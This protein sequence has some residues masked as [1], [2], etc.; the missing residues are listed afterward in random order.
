[1][2]FRKDALLY[3]C[4]QTFYIALILLSS[5]LI[6]IV[7]F[8]LAFLCGFPFLLLLPIN[9]ALYNEFITLD[10]SGISCQKT[11]K[12]VWRYRWDEIAELKRGSRFLLPSIEIIA[13]SRNGTPEQF[14]SPGHYFQHS[15]AAKMAIN[16]YYNNL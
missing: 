2:V 3:F 9:P 4:S 15:K 7:G 11:E 10:E 12:E 5:V 6:P 1:M 8:G 14:A 13:Y 16:K